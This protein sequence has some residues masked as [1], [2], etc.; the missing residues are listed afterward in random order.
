MRTCWRGMS[1][2]LF[3]SL[4]LA[5]RLPLPCQAQS[6]KQMYGGDIYWN[7]TPN[8]V[9]NLLK[10]LQELSDINYNMDLRSV[11]GQFTYAE[12]PRSDSRTQHPHGGLGLAA[13]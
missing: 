6:A 7:A 10:N 13:G 5:M 11:E 12:A 9:N 1:V 3:C 8:D 2:V 4:A